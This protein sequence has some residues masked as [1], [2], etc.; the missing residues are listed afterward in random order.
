[1]LAPC[2][3]QFTKRD[4]ARRGREPLE[5]IAAA[6]APVPSSSTSRGAAFAPSKVRFV[7]KKPALVENQARKLSVA[8]AV[9]KASPY[10]S[11]LPP[12]HTATARAPTPPCAVASA[13]D[14]QSGV[15]NAQRAHHAQRARRRAWWGTPAEPFGRGSAIEPGLGQAPAR[16]PGTLASFDTIERGN[17]AVGPVD[18]ARLPW[19]SVRASATGSLARCRY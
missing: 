19:L 7:T 10:R 8:L 2:H 3:S 5:P 15:Q 9:A 16:R 17:V 14:G 13:H 11:G 18:A 12:K 6:I 4:G 1:M